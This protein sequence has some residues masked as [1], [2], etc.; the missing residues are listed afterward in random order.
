MRPILTLVVAATLGS[1]VLVPVAGGQDNAR[2]RSLLVFAV[3]AE[4]GLPVE[5]LAP[6]DVVIREDGVAREILKV[7]RSADPVDITILVDNSVASTKAIQDM[8]IG[9]EKFVAAFAGP[10]P[11]TLMTVADRPTIQVNST[12]S[13]AQ[14]QRGVSRIFMQP[15]A[16][17]TLLEAIIEASRA[18][19]KR[20][21]A[22]SAIIAITSFGAEF[23]DRGYQF[24]LDALADSGAALHVI[25]LQDTQ[26]ASQQNTNVRDRNI[27]ID[28]GTTDTGGSRELLLANLSL[29]DALQKVG[30]VATTQFEVV[31]GRPDTLIPARKVEVF[32]AR[33]TLKIRGNTLQ[34]NRA[35]R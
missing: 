30:R 34:V 24:A 26:Q 33:P 21:P 20:K 28:R 14:L 17:A 19:G 23:S 7:T 35:T 16:G 3:S 10:H 1:S 6:D 11:I 13:K 2:Q 29:T 9:L 8:R 22:R 27:V 18:V 12:T 4:D 5:T 32:S 15:E 31:Y 25:E